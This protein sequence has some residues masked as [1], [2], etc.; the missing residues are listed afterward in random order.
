MNA[1]KV[2]RHPGIQALQKHLQVL[3][4][5]TVKG[6][7]SGGLNRQV[8]KAV[9]VRRAAKET[10]TVGPVRPEPVAPI[11]LPTLVARQGDRLGQST[12][13]AANVQFVCGAMLVEAR[14][15]HLKVAGFSGG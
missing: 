8:K 6:T 13:D 11:V 5:G 4:A 9:R 1:A 2:I 7:P 14:N 3:E 10:E 15:P 12:S